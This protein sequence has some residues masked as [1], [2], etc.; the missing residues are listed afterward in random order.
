M[1]NQEKFQQL[2]QKYTP[3]ELVDAY[4]V[5]EILPEEE[6]QLANQMLKEIRLQKIANQTEEQRL[7]S[8]LLRFKFQ[9]EDIVKK[10]DFKP[11]SSFAKFF[12]AYIQL[13]HISKK[14]F[15]ED[16]G[17]H[18]TKLSRILNDREEP[19]VELAYRLEKH[20]N[21]LINAETWW[22]LSI[23]KQAYKISQDN[24]TRTTEGNKVKNALQIQITGY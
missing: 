18:Y 21:G 4:M 5:P 10:A 13:L 14:Q 3:E 6:L 16:I 20:S 11:E 19:N 24:V 1:T 8:D 2:A 9:V 7:L 12:E 22:K 23:L 15:A 17:L